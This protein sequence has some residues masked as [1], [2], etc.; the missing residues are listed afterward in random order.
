MAWTWAL[1]LVQ[2]RWQEMT[3]RRGGIEITSLLAT[4]GK[5]D[6]VWACT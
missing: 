3:L 5:E 2:V 6:E 1:E 4:T